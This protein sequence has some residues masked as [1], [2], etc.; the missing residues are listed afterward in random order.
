[1]EVVDVTCPA[2]SV[3]GDVIEVS[4]ADGRRFEV[5]VPAALTEGCV[6]QVELHHDDAT[7]SGLRAVAAAM[8]DARAIAAQLYGG[9]GSEARP[10][11]AGEVLAEALRSLLRA[12]EDMDELDEL[13]EDSCAAFA[14]YSAEGEQELAWTEQFNQYVALVDHGISQQVHFSRA[15]SVE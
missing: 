11:R 7:P 4:T 6:F 14:Q 9:A 3:G 15:L 13:I 12:V 10:V 8:E 1:M 2:G 5:E